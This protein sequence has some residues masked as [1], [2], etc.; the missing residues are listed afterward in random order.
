MDVRQLE[1]FRA[2]V[3]EGT[4]TRAAERLHVSQSAIS[5]Q[6]Q[7]LEQELKT[8]LLHRA[9]RGVTLT[10]DGEVLLS[11]AKRVD[12][13]IQEAVA[14]I[15]G[16]RELQHGSVSLGGGMTVALY[17]FPKLLKRFRSTYKNVDLRITTGEADLLL[18]LLRT[19]QV[20]LALLTLPIVA[21]DLEVMPVLKE[22]M[23]VVTA[24][25]HPLTRERAI[26]AKK[27]AR[28]PF[29][30]FELGSN[31]RK[32]LDDFFREEEIPVN[33]VMQTENVEIIKAM[34]ASG[35]GITIL[36]YSAIAGE[37]KHGR[38]GWARIRGKRLYRETGWVYLKSEYLPRAVT[39]V[40]R[41]FDEMKNQFGGKPPGK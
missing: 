12:S 14:Q 6:L 40:L 18:R 32:V 27:L 2:V 16:T 3:E 23:V 25:N 30:L 20:D 33:V 11:T 28:Y 21:A 39:E 37:H 31:T 36:P 35:L 17:I 22:E 38:F 7:L 24:L 8:L 19:R 13:E 5:R 29:V 10:P 41:V 1:M 4:F 26:D 34:V 9:G 15:S